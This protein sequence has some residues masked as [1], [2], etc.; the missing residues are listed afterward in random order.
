MST[1]LNKLPEVIYGM[2]HESNTALPDSQRQRE[3]VKTLAHSYS[4]SV[5]LDNH[6]LKM[7]LSGQFLLYCLPKKEKITWGYLRLPSETITWE[8]E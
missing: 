2:S 6:F 3:D 5:R 8:Q 7:K 4:C 1:R